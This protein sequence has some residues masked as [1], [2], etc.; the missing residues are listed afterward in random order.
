MNK[1]LE[2]RG[3]IGSV[4]CYEE[5]GSYY[6][7]LQGIRAFV[8]YEG[9]TE[10]EFIADFHVAVDDYLAYCE[11]A[12]KEPEKPFSSCFNI[13]MSADNYRAANLY[14]LSQQMSLSNFIESCVSERLKAL[15][16][17]Y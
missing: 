13:N 7:T 10:E 3:Y 1:M 15:Q 5:D 4:E 11:G 17:A 12:G 6:G 14:A 9:K 8:F 2:Y 16:V